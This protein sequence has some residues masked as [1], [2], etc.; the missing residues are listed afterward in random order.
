M[1]VKTEDHN[2]VC[3]LAVTGDFAGEDVKATRKLF[4]DAIDRRHLA[5]VVVDL[6]KAGFVDSEALELLLWMKQ[7]CED[8]FG[9]IKLVGLDENVRKILE[10]TR[11]EARFETHA[12][13]ASALKT[14]K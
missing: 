1:P 2:Q 5:D 12:D 8:L 9:R 4:E 11:L 3:V 6:E 13:L 14:M 10:L 7:R